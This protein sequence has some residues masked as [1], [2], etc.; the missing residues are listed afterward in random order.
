MTE[1]TSNVSV[2]RDLL[3]Q[4]LD[5]SAA[6]G[7]QDVADEL[8]RLLTPATAATAVRDLDKAEGDQPDLNTHASTSPVSWLDPVSGRAAKSPSGRYRVPLC[9]FAELERLQQ[10]LIAAVQGNEAMHN[11]TLALHARLADRESLL[12]H[13]LQLANVCD[14]NLTDLVKETRAMLD[15]QSPTWERAARDVLTERR[16]QI[17]KGHTAVLD[18]IYG[19]GEL[20][21]Y[22]VIHSLLATGTDP[23][24]D[25][26]NLIC[27]WD[28]KQAEPR[29]MLVKAIA[30]Q[31]AALESLDRTQAETERLRQLVLEGPA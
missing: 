25:G 31:L 4:A 30:L 5:A 21:A 10:C 17:S 22:G 24:W 18:D 20:T 29:P 6:V 3:E 7:M 1:P 8:D 13:W 16:R 26:I 27:E 9:T 23:E 12:D 2:P 15:Q 19:P 14:D 11:E 28:V